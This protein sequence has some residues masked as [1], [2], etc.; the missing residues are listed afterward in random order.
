MSVKTTILDRRFYPCG[1]SARSAAAALLRD[2]AAAA[3]AA[4]TTRPRCGAGARDGV[5]TV[6]ASPARRRRLLLPLS[7]RS[8]RE[9]LC[10]VLAGMGR[11]NYTPARSA[12]AA[13]AWWPSTSIRP[14][15][16]RLR[17]PAAAAGMNS[18]A[19]SRNGWRQPRSRSRS[20]PNGTVT[21][22]RLKRL[23]AR[24]PAYRRTSR[25]H[26]TPRQPEAGWEGC[27]CDRDRHSTKWASPAHSD[28]IK[29]REKLGQ[30]RKSDFT[31]LRQK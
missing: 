24:S 4:N 14:S 11:R 9:W 3:S 19:A 10:H 18:C 1:G 21:P 5:A 30:Q 2:L 20:G 13:R 22:P 23:S 17:G 26:S 31:L 29:V 6:P 27:R 7:K 8:G 12:T 25:R 28:V 16:K 15:S